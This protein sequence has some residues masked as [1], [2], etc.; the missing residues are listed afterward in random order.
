MNFLV[1]RKPPG[2]KRSEDVARCARA[3]DALL[4]ARALVQASPPSGWVH[5]YRMHKRS[6]AYSLFCEF[7]FSGG[8]AERI[9]RALTEAGANE[10]AWRAKVKAENAA[11]KVRR[12]FLERFDADSLS[13]LLN[14]GAF[15][16]AV[17]G[18]AVRAEEADARAAELGIIPRVRTAEPVAA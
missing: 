16:R 2:A 9:N 7:D 6:V 13:K 12:A 5:V 10:K 1:G 14:D 11:R 17:F 18:D 8:A 3:V 4:F 15:G